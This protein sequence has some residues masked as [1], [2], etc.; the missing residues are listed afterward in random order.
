MWGKLGEGALRRQ[1]TLIFDP[2]ELYRFLAT[3]GVKVTSLLF[4]KDQAVWISWLHTGE[5]H[6]PNLK[7]AHVVIASYVTAGARIHLY[8][9]LDTLQDKALYCD[10][11]SV[12]CIQPRGDPSLIETRDSLGDMSSEL[13]PGH[14]I[15]EFVCAGP[16]KYAYMTVD[17][18]TSEQRTVCKVRGITLNYSASQLVNFESIKNMVLKR[19]NEETLTMRTEKQ[20]KRKWDSEGVHV[21][22]E[23]AEKIYRVS[24][25]KP[26]R[27]HNNSSVPFGYVI[28][29]CRTQNK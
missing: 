22:T 19:G 9:Y 7:D 1:T 23:P 20:I 2:Q 13:A 16:K 8:R 5:E 21:I 14:H 12:I 15:R 29:R 6:A 17:P 4:V 26:K 11:D 28:L 10:T 27:M 3:P 18:A 25:L 24:F